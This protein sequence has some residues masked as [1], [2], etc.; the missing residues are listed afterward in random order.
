MKEIM[1]LK[2]VK[3]TCLPPVLG[4]RQKAEH[5]I[6]LSLVYILQ[7]D[8]NYLLLQWCLIFVSSFCFELCIFHEISTNTYILYTNQVYLLAKIF[9]FMPI[10]RCDHWSFVTERHWTFY[11]AEILFSRTLFICIKDVI[12]ETVN[13]ILFHYSGIN[14]WSAY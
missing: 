14:P 2:F 6:Y 8:I 7:I 4:I 1:T 3:R 13:S 5:K 12:F 11:T 10:I 9:Y